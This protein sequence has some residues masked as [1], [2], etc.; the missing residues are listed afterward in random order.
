MGKQQYVFFSITELHVAVNNIKVLSVATEVQKWV[1]YALF[2]SYKIFRTA[3]NNQHILRSVRK[4][5]DIFV[6]F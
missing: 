1:L 2:S 3:V 6:R 4:F 5:P